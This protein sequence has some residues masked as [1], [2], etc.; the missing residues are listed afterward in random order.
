MIARDE[1]RTLVKVLRSLRCAIPQECLPLQVD[2]K[3]FCNCPSGIFWILFS[4]QAH[5]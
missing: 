3:S 2:M 5:I 1:A 4:T